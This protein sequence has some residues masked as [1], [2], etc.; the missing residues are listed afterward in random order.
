MVIYKYW[1]WAVWS[2]EETLPPEGVYTYGIFGLGWYSFN[3]FNNPPEGNWWFWYT[4]EASEGSEP[5]VIPSGTKY[6]VGEGGNWS[7]SSH[8]ALTPGGIGGNPMPAADEVAYIDAP[9]V[10]GQT[11]TMDVNV[12]CAGITSNFGYTGHEFTLDF[13][14]KTVNV[15]SVTM[16]DHCINHVDIS[17]AVINTA[18]WLIMEGV[19]VTAAG[20]II[21]IIQRDGQ[22]FFDDRNMN[23]YCDLNLN[24]KGK[25]G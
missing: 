19:S 16:A 4:S 25:N 12:T 9:A 11:I 14:E 2:G 17:N 8:W 3:D 15:G 18:S 5:P 7:D 6:W 24:F 10:G 20:S 21:N 23:T 13:N 22:G 1:A